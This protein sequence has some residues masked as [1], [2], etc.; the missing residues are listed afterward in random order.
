MD[1]NIRSLTETY[2]R[3]ITAELGVDVNKFKTKAGYGQNLSAQQKKASL[4]LALEK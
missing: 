3:N 2:E 4:S 1:E